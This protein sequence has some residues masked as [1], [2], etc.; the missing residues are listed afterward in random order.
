MDKDFFQMNA[1]RYKDTIYRIALNYFRNTYDAD[2]ILQEVLLTFYTSK[3]QFE[4]E[5]YLRNW[6]IRITINKCKN[7]LRG[8]WLKKRVSLEALT[9]SIAFEQKEES[10]LF[11]MVMLLP[12]QSRIV[13]YLYYYEDFSVKEIS[14][15]L[16]IKE[17]AVTSRLSRARQKLK[18]Q[19]MEEL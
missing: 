12:K 6:L 16:N 4:T 19:L 1:N 2:D 8:A 14:G 3:K 5:E 18:F 17:T 9:D 15:I 10:D 13:I 7:I 11:E